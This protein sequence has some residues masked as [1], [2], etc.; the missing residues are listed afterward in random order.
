MNSTDESYDENYLNFQGWDANNF[1]SL[2]K[3][4]E[5][6]FFAELKRAKK[7]FGRNSDV[8]EIG[9]GNGAFLK[10]ANN[11][12]WNIVGV[13][14]NPFLV[15]TANDNGF[16][17]YCTEDLGIFQ[18]NKFDLI[19]AFDV[20]EHIPQNKIVDFLAQVKR[21][22]KPNG[23]FL[24]RFPN[25]DSPFGLT[26][27]HGDVTHITSVGSGK[28][29]YFVRLVDVELVYCGGDAEI[30]F[31]GNVVEILYK[32]ISYVLRR[33][34]DLFVYVAFYKRKNFSSS[35]LVMIFK[36]K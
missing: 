9:F 15:K 6:Y 28:V 34:V 5:K 4:Q 17:A 3:Y 27:Q 32:S 13:E 21:M 29:H 19:V 11:S 10:F 36:K 23:V 16:A 1:G 20:L 26:I 30:V 33:L 25:A 2:S 12:G 18:N 24:A 8:L 14:L 31:V 7:L 35:N 22:L